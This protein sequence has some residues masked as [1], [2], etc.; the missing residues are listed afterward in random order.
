[1]LYNEDTPNVIITARQRSK[2][3]T[4]GAAV[5]SR[6]SR[7][8]AIRIEEDM[9]HIIT[10]VVGVCNRNPDGTS[11]QN[12]LKKFAKPGAEVILNHVESSEGDLNTIEV[13]LPYAED[14]KPRCIGFLPGRVGE[15]LARRLDANH[16][17]VAV[18][19]DLIT[20]DDPALHVKISF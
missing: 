20:E 8:S 3:V 1:M 10:R 2:V 5:S 6:K 4:G 17:V 7:V 14:K 12:L 19:H 15:K 16:P 9:R 11:R 13:L 18:I